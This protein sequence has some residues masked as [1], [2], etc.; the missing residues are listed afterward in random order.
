M[1]PFSISTHRYF[2]FPCRSPCWRTIN[3]MSSIRFRA[4]SAP[5]T[6]AIS[7]STS[8]S[9]VSSLHILFSSFQESVGRSIPYQI[10]WNAVERCRKRRKPSKGYIPSPDHGK[11]AL[12]FT[13]D[14][15]EHIS[16]IRWPPGHVERNDSLQHDQE[17]FFVRNLS[18][19]IVSNCYEN[20]IIFLILKVQGFCTFKIYAFSVER[21]CGLNTCG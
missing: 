12:N 19:L 9:S 21:R 1:K 10:F 18:F 8:L 14:K 3:Q 6:A 17:A 13:I 7:T 20:L 15:K 11:T 16:H 4:S 2:I 5:L